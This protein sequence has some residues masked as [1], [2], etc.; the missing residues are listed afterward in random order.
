MRRPQVTG[1]RP[2]GFH[3]YALIARLPADRISGRQ[4]PPL[5]D[6]RSLA[7]ARKKLHKIVAFLV[8]HERRQGAAHF[9]LL[10][11]IRQQSF[12]FVFLRLLPPCSRRGPRVQQS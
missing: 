4:T 11:Q 2:S 1:F 3:P 7:R 8:L 5:R 6:R 10:V 12:S 9:V